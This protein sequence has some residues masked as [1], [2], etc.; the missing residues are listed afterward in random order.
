MLPPISLPTRYERL[1]AKAREINADLRRIVVKVEA[2]VEHLQELFL[3]M[4]QTD[5]CRF[6]VF[7]GA[8]GSGKTTFLETLEQFFEGVTVHKLDST[9]PLTESV[10]KIEKEMQ[11][12]RGLKS[13]VYLA[14]RDNP[15]ETDDELLT[16]FERLRALFRRID[17]RLLVVWPISLKDKSQHLFDLA[18]SIGADS[19]IGRTAGPYHFRGPP[20]AQYY[21]IADD[22]AR[23]FNEGSGLLEFGIDE[24]IGTGVLSQAATLGAYFNK[25]IDHSN[26]L[27]DIIA[28][29]L[30]E[31]P[32][33]RVWVVVC[34][35]E[36]TELMSTVQ[37]L[38]FGNQR[39]LDTTKFTA[40][41]GERRRQTQYMKDWQALGSYM[42]FLL[43][44]LDVKVIEVPP[45][46]ALAVVRAFGDQGIRNALK[47]KSA[48]KMNTID[49]L[50]ESVLGELVTGAEPRD[51]R[52]PHKTGADTRAEFNRIQARAKAE[53]RLLNKAFAAAFQELFARQQKETVSIGERKSVFSTL[54]PDV[55]IDEPG[56]DPICLEF[57]WRTT[58][59]I[60]SG[61]RQQKTF[62]PGHIQ[63]YVFQKAYEYVKALNLHIIPKTQKELPGMPS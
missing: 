5:L 14:D 32:R 16:F 36:D 49:S 54:V 17:P 12:S 4:Q 25:I 50:Q 31:K 48:N 39:A 29:V 37:S 41:V 59:E 3:A 19:L 21:A 62:T 55:L 24:T 6:E 7:Y 22:T 26:M 27:N 15:T 57:T 45:N 8:S 10:A 42:T 13:I 34:G 2:S 63:Q 35:D 44:M 18:Q 52:A 9:V 61:K 20:N 30:R 1:E 23:M 40:H 28:D 38:T 33:P 51:R 53:D 58:G 46:L 11:G 56:N 60:A 47:Q 43:R